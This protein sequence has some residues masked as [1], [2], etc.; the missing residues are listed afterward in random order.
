MIVY[1]NC[2]INIG[3]NIIKRRSDGFHDIESIM[4]P[5]KSLCDVVEVVRNSCNEIRYSESGVIVDCPVEANLCVR[6]A[7]L[8]QTEYHVGGVDI[9][10]HKNIPFGAGLGGGSAN[11]TSVIIAINSLFE[12]NLSVDMMKKLAAILGSDTAFFVENIP[13]L[14]EGRGEV[15]SAV[16]L[17]LAGKYIVLIKPD[18]AVSTAEAYAG[19][20]PCVPELSLKE[21]ITTDMSCWRGVVVNDFEKSL[22]TKYP[23]LSQIK[24]DLY[25]KGAIYAS[26]SGSGSS[27]YGIFDEKPEANFDC[28][29]MFIHEATL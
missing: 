29:D 11:A 16:D 8:M 22:F 14:T 26:M 20:T 1:S 21:I 12:L 7:K 4:Y 10:L 5:L 15:L 17:N 23:E 19:V 2:K 13:Q 25:A 18:I 27:V 24:S 9:H 28:K 6:A 3:L